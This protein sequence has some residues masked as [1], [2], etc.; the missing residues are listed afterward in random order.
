[1]SAIDEEKR[2][3]ERKELEATEKIEMDKLKINPPIGLIQSRYILT[4]CHSTDSEKE[5]EK[6]NLMAAVKEH[7]KRQVQCTNCIFFV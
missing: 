3:K 1:M 4:C 6:A 5:A 2:E 7:S